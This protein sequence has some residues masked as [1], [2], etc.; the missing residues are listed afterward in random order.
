MTP[1]KTRV[2]A[3]VTA[4]LWLVSA[5]T[6]LVGIFLAIVFGVHYSGILFGVVLLLAITCPT[7]IYFWSLFL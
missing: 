2:H 6:V 7:L 3:T 4:F 1:R 5:S